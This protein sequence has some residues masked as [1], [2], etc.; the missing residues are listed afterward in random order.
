MTENGEM[1]CCF[2]GHRTIA[3]A[4]KI[5][6]RLERELRVL[7]DTYPL[8]TFL[9]GSRSAFNDLCHAVVTELKG[10][11][12]DVKRIMYACKSECACLESKR[13]QTNRLASALL[14]KPIEFQ[15]YEEEY[16]FPDYLTAGRAS[17]IERN[18]AMIDDSDI[19][20]FYCNKDY[21]L[22]TTKSGTAIAYDYANK[23][24]KKTGK[25]LIINIFD[26]TNK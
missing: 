24:S 3:D 18:Q 21:A 11:Y 8:R 22:H 6:E 1:K 16:K 20:I 12:P 17:Y 2:I 13:E 26:D 5:Y 25:P 4:Q 7:I 14:K 15:G 23:L 19:C 10:R 9:F